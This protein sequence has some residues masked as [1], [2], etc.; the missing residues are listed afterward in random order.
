[1]KQA[2]SIKIK[3]E[4][5][6][7]KSTGACHPMSLYSNYIVNLHHRKGWA[8][9]ISVEHVTG[10]SWVLFLG[11]SSQPGVFRENLVYVDETGGGA[12]QYSSLG[13]TFLNYKVI[14]D[15]IN[16]NF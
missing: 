16:D 7:M 4:G 6:Y 3:N 10:H 11:K 5:K 14:N 13:H 2:I 12:I 9:A 15:C 8:K 1:L